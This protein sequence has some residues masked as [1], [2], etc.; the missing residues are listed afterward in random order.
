MPILE[1]IFLAVSDVEVAK[2]FYVDKLGFK[3]AYEGGDFVI[4][5]TDGGPSLLLHSAEGEPVSPGTFE[6]EL[7]VDDVD[8][9]CED[10]SRKG[11]QFSKG[12][13]EV[14]HEG[15]PWSPR[16]EARLRDPDG[17][18]LTLFHPRKERRS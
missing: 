18:G 6:M 4:V 2:D 1:E 16:R 11:V 10:L 14:S 17:Y 12:P 3:L 9:V 15:D 13:F 7:R 8:R 5:R